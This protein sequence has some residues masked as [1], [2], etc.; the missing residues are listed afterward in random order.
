V[1]CS[2]CS[3]RPHHLRRAVPTGNARAGGAGAQRERLATCN[4][5]VAAA[6]KA[7]ASISAELAEDA[8]LA[9]LYRTMKGAKGVTNR[10]HLADNVCDKVNQLLAAQQV[11]DEDP[12][13]LANQALAAVMSL[14]QS[15][16]EAFEGEVE[17]LVLTSDPELRKGVA[18]LIL[19]RVSEAQPKADTDDSRARKVQ[20]A[21]LATK[22]ASNGSSQKA[23]R[24]ELRV[25]SSESQ[26]EYEPI[27]RS[28]KGGLAA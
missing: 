20:T 27:R 12:E 24:R 17:K 26:P 7:F 19:A 8:D 4:R 3:A 18:S 25:V 16:R 23:R 21:P 10:M 14:E 28:R 13:M 2:A 22:K 1:G 15:V 6:D 11:K 9:V 5:K